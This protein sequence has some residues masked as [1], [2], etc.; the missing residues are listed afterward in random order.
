[1]TSPIFHQLFKSV[2]PVTP[3]HDKINYNCHGVPEKFEAISSR[4][5]CTSLLQRTR[6]HK[7]TLS[8]LRRILLDPKP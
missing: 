3:L 7:E 2:N 5:I 1:V 6:F 8:Y 4:R